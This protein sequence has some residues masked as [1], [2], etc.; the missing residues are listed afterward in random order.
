MKS[1]NDAFKAAGGG[2]DGMT[3][4]GAKGELAKQDAA[5]KDCDPME[6][7]PGE[8][9]GGP[10]GTAPDGEWPTERDGDDDY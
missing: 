2:G 6:P 5:S 4:N 1:V 3:T 7:A 8:G 9:W 10:M